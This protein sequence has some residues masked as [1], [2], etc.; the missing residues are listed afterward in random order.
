MAE[1]DE[2]LERDGRRVEHGVLLD[3]LFEQV[4]VDPAV[5]HG[6]GGGKVVASERRHKT[7]DVVDV[8]ATQRSSRFEEDSRH[9]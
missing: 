1:V 6:A 7:S 4:V 2:V 3:L 9:G 5:G 8:D